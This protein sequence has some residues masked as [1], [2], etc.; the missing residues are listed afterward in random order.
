MNEL[1]ILGIKETV[2]KDKEE[3]YS[4]L[5]YINTIFYDKILNN[6]HNI[7]KYEKC[8]EIIE[9]TKLRL[10]GNSNYDMTIDNLLLSIERS[11]AN[12]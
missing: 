7:N 3:V 10:K 2:F 1:Q 4:I 5:D 8:I 12:G 6:I 9:E 11:M